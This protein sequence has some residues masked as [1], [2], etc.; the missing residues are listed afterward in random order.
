[1]S[2]NQNES[3]KEV[4]EE[5]QDLQQI[6]SLSKSR[7]FV[8]PS[9]EIYGGL[10]ACWDYGPLGVELKL[11]VKREWWNSMVYHREDIEGLDAAILMHPR[12]WEA[13]GHVKNFNDPLVDCK[14]CKVRYRADHLGPV[15]KIEASTGKIPSLEEMKK[16]LKD[17]NCPNCG[18]KNSLTEPRLFN[19]MFR[20][21]MSAVE[22]EANA[23][24]FRPETAQGIFVNFQN[25]Y[26]SSRRK[27]PFGIAQIG[28][29]F[30]NEITPGNFIFRTR[31][32]EQ[33]EM[34]YFVLEK[35]GKKYFEDWKEARVKWHES[36]GIKKEKLR[37]HEHGETELAHY[38]KQAS[39]IQYKFPFGWKELEGI[40]NRGDFDLS[41][42]QKY[43]G[44]NLH[45]NFN[46]EQL[47]PHVIETAVGCDRAVLAVLADA[48]HRS[49]ERVVL[50]LHPKLSPYKLAVLPLMKKEELMG[51]TEQI[52]NDLR[53][54]FRCDKDL[55]GSIGKRYR[56]QEEIG[57]P[58]CVTID[59][60]TAKDQSVTVRNRDTMAQERV[61][62]SHLESYVEE[63]IAKWSIA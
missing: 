41:Q 12:V 55:S 4:L 40:H 60:D 42:H 44:K 23:I 52:Y 50:M 49:K 38:C 18:D 6:V 1:M 30:R 45:C 7:G 11:A 13:S 22:D 32:F 34:Q 14:N 53:T 33:M 48:Y 15:S 62:M 2:G 39:D 19:M 24:Y 3:E 20:S 61:A 36:L 10:N 43:S 17:V 63:K 35:D 5:I 31:E 57:T 29:S 8:F 56:R 37:F 47:I 27:I 46:D 25:I 28:K 54:K 59:Y 21:H 51:Y 16:L 26:R 9:S 58:F